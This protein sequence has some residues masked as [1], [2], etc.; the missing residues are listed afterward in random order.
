MRTELFGTI[1][2]VQIPVGIL[3]KPLRI[4]VKSDLPSRQQRYGQH[5]KAPGIRLLHK[6]Q[7]RKHHRIVPVINTARAAAFILK[8]PRLERAEKQN[9]YKIAHGIKRTQ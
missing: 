7:W 6:K 5:Q 3:R 1:D 2:A 4:T 9:T 8:K